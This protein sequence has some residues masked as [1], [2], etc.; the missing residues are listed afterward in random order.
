MIIDKARWQSWE[1]AN[2]DPYGKACVD[3]A[4]EVMRLLD[5]EEYKEFDPNEIINVALGFL[6][7]TNL[8]LSDENI[9]AG[10]ITGFQ[11]G[12]VAQMISQVHSRGKEFK[13]KWNKSYGAEKAKGTVNPAILQIEPK[14]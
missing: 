13:K 4:R 2:K 12:C 14:R 10:G 3:V 7:I 5:M 1:K 11:A 8:K 6:S 9:K